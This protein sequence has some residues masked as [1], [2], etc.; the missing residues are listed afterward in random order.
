M[1]VCVCVT[2]GSNIFSSSHKEARDCFSSRPQGTNIGARDSCVFVDTILYIRPLLS[3]IVSRVNTQ[4]LS[5]GNLRFSTWGFFSL[6][7]LR[8]LS[9]SLL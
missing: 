9:R 2:S 1:C 8:T 7:A 6:S 4:F 5:G 3:V